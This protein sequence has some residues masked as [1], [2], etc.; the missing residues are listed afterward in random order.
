MGVWR[1]IA[2]ACVHISEAGLMFVDDTK[3]ELIQLYY[4]EQGVALLP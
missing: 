1:L 3:M 2:M 4:A